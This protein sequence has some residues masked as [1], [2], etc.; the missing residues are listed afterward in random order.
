MWVLGAVVA[1]VA[2]LAMH[3]LDSFAAAAPYDG[4][5]TVTSI[6]DTH[7]DTCDHPCP[8]PGHLLVVCVA[9]IGMAVA[10][11]RLTH[12]EQRWRPARARSGPARAVRR[13]DRRRVRDPIWVR[14]A[15]IQC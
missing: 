11:R 5:A 9:V 3:G 1:V 4:S 7:G 8:H 2:V 15:V 13:I 14:L 6:A 12:A 10:A